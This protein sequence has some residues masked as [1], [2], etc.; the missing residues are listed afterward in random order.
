MRTGRLSPLARGR[1]PRGV[2]KTHLCAR[3]LAAACRR[4]TMS[5]CS[6][7]MP[8]TVAAWDSFCL[9]LSRHWMSTSVI[10]VCSTA[11][12]CLALPLLSD[13]SARGLRTACLH[14]RTSHMDSASVCQCS[15]T[16]W[17][18]SRRSF[19]PWSA[20][21]RMVP[22]ETLLPPGFGELFLVCKEIVMCSGVDGRATYARVLT[23]VLLPIVRWRQ[24]AG[25]W[26]CKQ[27]LA[28]VTQAF[29]ATE[30]HSQS[31]ACSMVAVDARCPTA[32]HPCNQMLPQNKKHL[33]PAEALVL[34]P[35]QTASRSRH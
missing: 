29:V 34:G 9:S 2:L 14:A 6:L 35:A 25:A 11:E 5:C 23:T 20:D 16:V 33:R 24:A 13:G 30:G 28:A 8:L 18:R 27:R 32:L 7:H 12:Q 1:Y 22:D 15:Q 3:F 26:L 10:Y 31:S 4:R 17:L 19:P 21:G